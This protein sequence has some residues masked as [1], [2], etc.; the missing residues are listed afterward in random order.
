MTQLHTTS[1]PGTGSAAGTGNRTIPSYLIIAV[2]TILTIGPQYF[3]NVS[4]ILNQTLIQNT[5]TASSKGLL[6]LSIVSNLAFALC[7]PI[8]PAVTRRY[9]IR[10]SYPA[11][12][13]VFLLGSLLNMFAPG[14]ELLLLGRILQGFASGSL[15]LTILPVSLRSFPNRVRNRFLLLAIGGLFGS[16]AIGALLGSLSL[17]SDT[18]RWLFAVSAVTSALCLLIGPSALPAQPSPQTPRPPLD[19]SGIVSLA[20]FM[21]ALTVPLYY[22]Q[23]KGL[24]SLYVWP[25]F[26]ICLLLLILFLT[27]DY[28]KENPLLPWKALLFSKP[29][30]G[31]VMSI[32][33]HI[34]LIIALAGTNGVLRSVREIPF[35]NLTF[36]YLWFFTGILVSA[37]LC[38]VLY[39]RL[40]PGILGFVGSLAVIAVSLQWLHLD[41]K[42]PLSTMYLQI[43][44]LGGGISMTLISGA[45]GT[46]MAGNL[47]HAALR[48][49][50]L[51]FMRN[52]AGAVAAPFVG[53]FLYRQSAIHYETFR[54]QMSVTN[55]AL[56]VKMSELAGHLMAGGLTAS[57]AK[58]S[59]AST[60]LVEVKKS[61]L[62]G[63]Y[64]NLFT[65]LLVLGIVMLLASFGK[66]LTGKGRS[67]VQ[68]EQAPKA[69][70][71]QDPV[72]VLALP[73]PL[74]EPAGR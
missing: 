28:A 60:L 41:V 72:P 30:F 68:K 55:P 10:R 54:S 52:L 71:A 46:A 61:A 34:S 42:V 66:A 32:A 50:S 59:A 20:L 74:A 64:Q 73:Q 13:L 23:E 33:S 39:D 37:L 65:I 43:A 70:S 45:L 24:G 35:M 53:W 44:C 29:V 48:S 19:K 1:A 31:T 17:T 21:S 12:M 57:E 7:V 47:H 27:V 40:G 6:L 69:Q 22:L 8:G 49:V 5:L 2:L 18:W 14:M 36:F 9:G 25:F 51:H 63:A 16:S 3:L 38:T 58:K 62:L 4:F 26:L 11:F 15:F 67:L 56:N